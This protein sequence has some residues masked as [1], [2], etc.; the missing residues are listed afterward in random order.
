[1]SSTTIDRLDGLSSS[2]AIK[3]PCRVAT[4][5][6]I[7]LYGLQTIDGVAVS[8]GDRVLVKSQSASYENGIYVADTGQWRRSRDFNKTRDVVNGTQVL[9]TGGSSPN[10][11][12]GV[13]SANPV[14]VGT[15]PIIFALSDNLAAAQA[16]AAAAIAAAQNAVGQAAVPIFNSVSALASLS[17]PQFMNSIRVNGFTAAGDGGGGFYVRATSQPTGEYASLA[18]RSADRFLPDGSTSSANGGWWAFSQRWSA[19]EVM[20]DIASLWANGDV[21]D[22][23]CYGDS[24]TEGVGTT[25]RTENPVD[26][27]GDAI[28]TRDQSQF[29]LNAWPWRTEWVLK[30]VYPNFGTSRILNCGYTG[31]QM[32]DG[33]ATRN[34]QKAVIDNAFLITGRVPRAVIIAF[35]LNDV[36][37]LDTVVRKTFISELRAACRFFMSKGVVP[38]IQTCDPTWRGDAPRDSWKP[39]EIIDAIK[40]SVAAELGIPLMDTGSDIKT[41]MNCNKDGHNYFENQ[42]DALHGRDVWHSFKGGAVARHFMRN[43]VTRQAGKGAQRISNSSPEMRIAVDNSR[44]FQLLQSRDGAC[45]TSGAA[46]A[47]NG[48]AASM[49]VWNE[50]PDAEVIYRGVANEDY[51]LSQFTATA[52]RPRHRVVDITSMG[53]FTERYPANICFS[54]SSYGRVCDVPYRIMKLPFGL[55]NVHYRIDDNTAYFIGHYEIRSTPEW[56][57]TASFGKSTNGRY[58]RIELNALKGRGPYVREFNRGSSNASVIELMP[59]A[60]DMSNVVGLCGGD[61]AYIYLRAVIPVGTGVIIGWTPNYTNNSSGARDDVSILFLY[62]TSTAMNLYHGQRLSGVVSW[63]QRGGNGTI[64]QTADADGAYRF[65]IRHYR[66]ADTSSIEVYE[67]WNYPVTPMITYTANPGDVVPSFAYTMGGMIRTAETGASGYFNFRIM[68]MFGAQETDARVLDPVLVA[69]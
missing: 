46:L 17:V 27:N 62:R 51:G 16:A 19:L 45:Y 65:M 53:A 49:W 69:S 54:S 4:T 33:W 56:M 36:R 39:V 47:P 60:P 66:P 25:G 40:S 38:I 10:R 7:A 37:T 63:T 50:D 15:D 44:V 21:A 28:G 43:F 57:T 12:Y 24:T 34:M 8:S 32:V 6:N 26:G 41:W 11:W 2:A 58:T 31:T 61:L 67:G 22:V 5:G 9:V 30:A 3:G 59:T 23:A 1:M 42:P 48:L 55:S 68:E 29:A 18:F 13:T 35:G 20:Q 14:N 64:T 52:A